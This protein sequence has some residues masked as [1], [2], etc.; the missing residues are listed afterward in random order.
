MKRVWIEFCGEHA[1]F[2]ASWRRRA[3][4]AAALLFVCSTYRRS[5]VALISH[6]LPAK[7]L[8]KLRSIAHRR[9]VSCDTSAIDAACADS[10]NSHGASTHA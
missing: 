5:R 1:I 9:T 4:I 8:P 10:N 7:H 2:I 3:S 6:V